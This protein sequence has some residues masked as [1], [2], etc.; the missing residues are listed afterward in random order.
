LSFNSIPKGRKYLFGFRSVNLNFLHNN[1]PLKV[2]LFFL[3]E[4]QG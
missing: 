3:Q 4:S 2:I 1:S